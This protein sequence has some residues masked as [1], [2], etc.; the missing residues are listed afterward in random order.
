VMRLLAAG[1][2][3]LALGPRANQHD[4][5]HRVAGDKNAAPSSQ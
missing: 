4:C 2:W 1:Y 5:G 3:L